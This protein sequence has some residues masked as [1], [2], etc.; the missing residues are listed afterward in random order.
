MAA[1][2]AAPSLKLTNAPSGPAHAAECPLVNTIPLLIANG[3]PA[4]VNVPLATAG[5]VSITFKIVTPDPASVDANVAA[6]TGVVTV[7]WEK[8]LFEQR[9]QKRRRMGLQILYGFI[10]ATIINCKETHPALPEYY[11]HVNF[12]V[13]LCQRSLY[14][15]D[16]LQPVLKI[17]DD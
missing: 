1:S 7:S 3:V 11:W 4:A 6:D 14:I 9:I 5:H 12:V 10:I 17:I 13:K 16:I 2:P 8:E 15:T